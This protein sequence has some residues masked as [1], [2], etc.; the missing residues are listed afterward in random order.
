MRQ[1]GFIKKIHLGEINLDYPQQFPN[2][3]DGQ[4]RVAFQGSRMTTTL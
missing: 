4:S 1:S 3:S 2:A